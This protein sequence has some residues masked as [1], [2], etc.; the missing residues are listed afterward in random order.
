MRFVVSVFLAAVIALF[1]TQ[2]N[3][4]VKKLPVHK[5]V[6]GNG[7]YFDSV[8]TYNFNSQIGINIKHTDFED[9]IFDEPMWPEDHFIE[10][11]ELEFIYNPYLNEGE[12]VYKT[13]EQI[14]SLAKIVDFQ[15][16]SGPPSIYGKVVDLKKK[17]HVEVYMGDKIIFSKEIN[18]YDIFTSVNWNFQINKPDDEI[19][20]KLIH[21]LYSEVILD[22]TVEVEDRTV[23]I[24]GLLYSYNPYYEH[25]E[26]RYSSDELT[27]TCAIIEKKETLFGLIDYTDIQPLES[28]KCNLAV[29]TE[30][31][32]E[33]NLCLVS[34]S[35]LISD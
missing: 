3:A 4:N 2:I 19:G 23:K 25:G 30:P 20:I 9:V 31:V 26:I 16:I 7:D 17:K 29:K 11:P 13:S 27:H 35:L 24:P 8:F 5:E 21:A 34:V 32:C 15:I 14:I 1:S 22:E 12:I 28:G 10:L 18:K 6:I 33:N